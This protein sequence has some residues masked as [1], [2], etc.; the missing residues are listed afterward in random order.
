L[1][2]CLLSERAGDGGGGRGGR[3]S[4]CTVEEEQGVELHMEERGVGLRLGWCD[5]DL[6]DRQCR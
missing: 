3:R 1:L 4:E 5:A 6:G 2:L